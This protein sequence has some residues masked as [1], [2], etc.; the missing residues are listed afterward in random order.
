MK[1]KELVYS[2]LLLISFIIFTV[3]ITKYIRPIIVT[4]I[5]I[6]LSLPLY[7]MLKKNNTFGEKASAIISIVFI[8]SLFFI[9]LFALGN[10]V[11]TFGIT[12][13]KNQLEG[14][15]EYL[16]E[17]YNSFLPFNNINMNTLKNVIIEKIYYVINS[18]IITKGAI[19]T[20]GH[21]F[22]YFIG[23][24][25]AYFILSDTK[26][27]GC[28]IIRIIGKDNY[29][30]ICKK[31]CDLKNLIRVLFYSAFI[32]MIITIIGFIIFRI[33][34]PIS[35]GVICG[36]LDFVPYVGTVIVFIPLII[37]Y[38]CMGNKIISLALVILY[39][40]L[41]FNSQII[42]T[43]FMSYKMNISPL[44]MILSMYIGMKNFGVV[45]MVMG[46]LY[47]VTCDEFIFKNSCEFDK[48]YSVNKYIK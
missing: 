5:I 2:I 41:V 4:I 28:F 47:V 48:I 19:Y 1:Y 15:L 31:I 43:K 26:S 42:Q 17:I 27:I 37:Y 35:L 38:W 36:I 40:I 32:N 21:I 11:F 3:V 8:N 6:L 25:T 29:I 44:A 24:I 39:I 46:I 10:F 23:N 34:K 30:K 16:V 14:V 33:K 7:R 18:G 20:T 13:L 22:T 12:F 9:I 45:G